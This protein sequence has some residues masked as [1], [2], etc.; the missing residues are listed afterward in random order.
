MK[1]EI[2]LFIADTRVDLFKDESINITDSLQ[3]IL[4][5]SKIFTPF[6]QTFNLPASATN[7]KLFQHYYNY[8]ITGGFDARFQ[9]E[10]R[11]EINQVPFKNGKIRLDGVGMKNNLPYSYKVVFFGKPSNLNDL[12]GNE[13]LSSLNPLSTYDL[14]YNG[15]DLFH[16]LETGLQSSG[17]LA[18]N[19]SNRNVVLPLITLQNYYIFN[20]GTTSDPNIY[21]V[22]F[23]NL[24]KELKPAI[25]LKLI[26][27]AIQTQYGI[28]FNMSDEVT[29]DFVLAENNDNVITEVNDDFIVLESATATTKSFFG[30]DMFDGLY[31]WLHR[32]KT[33]KAGAN[34]SYSGIDFSTRNKKLTLSDFSYLCGSGD[35]LSGGKLTVN[36]GE[37][38]SIRV[39]LD[40]SI[41]SFFGK[42]KVIDITTNEL[43]FY[44]DNVTLNPAAT[45]TI[46]LTNLTSGTLDQRIYDIQFLIED[47]NVQVFSALT[48]CGSEAMRIIKTVNGVATNHDYS[49]AGFTLGYS[50]FIQDYLPK[51][52]IID[53]LT[54]LF[55]MF[56]LVAYTKLDSSTIYVE[57]FDNFMSAGTTRD[58]TKYIDINDST[59]DRSIPY[60]RI[61]FKYS[62][63]VT[64]TGLEYVDKFSKAF[65]DLS[66]SAPEK[67]DGQSFEQKLPFQ[68]SPLFNIQNTTT[69]VLRATGNIM[70]WW[71]DADSKPALGKPYI[72]FNR[73]L[74][75]SDPI[76]GGGTF[77]TYNAPSNISV[78][79]N[80]SL[81]FDNEYDVYN[82]VVNT[83][84][85]FNR[86]YQQ[87]IVQTFDKKNRI[88][89]VKAQLPISFML[90]YKLNDI[91]TIGTEEYYINSIRMNLTTGKSELELI[92][93]TATYTES[94]LT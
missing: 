37:T 2:Q 90:N 20:T 34:E 49:N 13:D 73:F 12:F 91:I 68:R 76:V 80:H 59:I 79:Q 5:I 43:L 86:F 40:P 11:I 60:S 52:K 3:N 22:T 70:G 71:V 36:A 10:A 30:S 38:Y 6:S 55:K 35:V 7:N 72:F 45:T 53:F 77:S 50:I 44:R 83:N 81:S 42:L 82:L 75:S 8:N 78:D 47:Q 1:R 39:R 58:I 23:A 54:G 25:K 65:A 62:D 93:K 74:T 89:K 16:A 27:E 9:V 32:E 48:V 26:I 92:V 61:D 63:P 51:M 19:D 46:T 31:L 94:V 57:T 17:V 87:Y 85:L 33:S 24:K 66:Y 21:D 88:V 28:T 67:Y 64:K 69:A 4:D 15:D 29:D 14:D 41:T 56:N 84:N 18:T